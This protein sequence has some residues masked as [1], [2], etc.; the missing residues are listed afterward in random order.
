MKLRKWLMTLMAAMMVAFVAT[1]CS[2]EDSDDPETEE[3]QEE[4]ETET[5]EESG[6]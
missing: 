5:E 6:E 2:N 3:N 4:T 1:G